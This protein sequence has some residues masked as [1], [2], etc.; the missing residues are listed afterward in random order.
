MIDFGLSFIVQAIPDEIRK[1]ALRESIRT[2]RKVHIWYSD[3]KFE[4]CS[5]GL[6]GSS[7]NANSATHRFRDQRLVAIVEPVRAEASDERL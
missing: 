1:R 6:C 7:M 4:R 2:G 5:E 3:G